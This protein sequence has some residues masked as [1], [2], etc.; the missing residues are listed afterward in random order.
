MI[1]AAALLL[2]VAAAHVETR[3]QCEKQFAP[4]IGE[5][6]K[7]VIWAP[8]Q[9]DLAMAMLKAANTTRDDYVVDLGAGDGKIP[10][11]AAKEFGARSLGIEYNPQLVKL[12]QCNVR[13]E[14]LEDKVQI[15][16]GDIFATDFSEATVLTLY[17]LSD[18][19]TKLRPTI[20]MM[21]PGTRVV[22]NTF[23]M[24]DWS[25][26]QFIE[27]EMGNTRAYL[28]IVPARVEGTW[29]FRA[30]DGSDSFRVS[31]N[32]H[33][34]EIEGGVLGAARSS[35]IRDARLHGAHIELTLLGHGDEPLALKGDVVQDQIDA[36]VERDGKVVRYL[37]VRD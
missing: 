34:Q 10:I 6:G 37:G 9:D 19:N 11:A 25:P 8:T 13:A 4:R 29:R 1:L 3:E 22:S 27:S 32:Q 28:W 12:A 16:Q 15:R 21:K 18:L 14:R 5:Q 7:D 30:A 26:D 36:S 33:Y 17:L 2:S 35:S 31:L 23:K 24:G 20:L